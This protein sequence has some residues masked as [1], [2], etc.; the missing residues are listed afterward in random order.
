MCGVGF[1]DFLECLSTSLWT[2]FKIVISIPLNCNQ[3]GGRAMWIMMEVE[4][5]I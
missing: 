2:N 3:S 5:A 4:L 1:S